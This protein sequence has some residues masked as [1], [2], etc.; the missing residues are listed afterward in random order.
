MA[1]WR[2]Q[3]GNPALRPDDLAYVSVQRA[4]M[5]LEPARAASWAIYLMLAVLAAGT[6][7][8][9]LARVDMITRGDARVIPEGR[10]QVIASPKAA[11]CAS[12]WCA[13]AM[14]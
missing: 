4:A 13:R 5:V 14:R 7:W 3:G 12:C 8:A 1:F 2:H 6:G 11:S 9:A 10:E